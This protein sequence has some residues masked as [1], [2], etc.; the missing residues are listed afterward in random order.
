MKFPFAGGP[1]AC[2]RALL[3]TAAWLSG[4]IVTAWI[5]GRCLPPAELPPV[6]WEKLDH[7]AA[8]GDEYDAIV[9][10]S[11]RAQFQIMPSVFD[12]VAAGRGIAVKTFNA[13]VA[14]MGPPE[15]GYMLDEILRRP[16]RRL[17]WVVIEMAAI[18]S[19]MDAKQ[20]GTS[21]FGYWHDWQRLILMTKRAR[22]Q[23]REVQS[24]AASRRRRPWLDRMGAYVA[25]VMLWMSHVESFAVRALDLGRAAP[26]VVHLA[27]PDAPHPTAGTYGLGRFGDG[28]GYAGDEYQRMTGKIL[29]DYEQAHAE[30]LQSPA[31]KDPHDAVSH[32]ALA[33]MLAKVVR[34][35]ARPILFVPP[36]PSK[37]H[38]FP[39]R[40]R[41]RE[42]TIFDFS[43][44]REYPELF[45]MENRQD[46]E[47]LNAAGAEVFSRILAQ[48]FVG[49][50]VQPSSLIP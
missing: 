30:R 2:A 8:H 45:K 5:A 29:A 31:R 27:M 17:R 43:D 24:T 20:V 32:E 22:Q 42:L 38:Y 13:G 25:P 10:G 11:S 7:L 28:W 3:A 40:A 14:A 21:R 49:Q 36:V 4:F 47:H 48:R 16:H 41:E 26:L 50:V 44:V 34:A 19:R 35:G 18:S 39:P 6:V 15:D 33:L 46:T 9:L 37:K 12:E 1:A 23:L